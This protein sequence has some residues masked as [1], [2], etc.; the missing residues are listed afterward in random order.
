MTLLFEDGLTATEVLA[1]WTEAEPAASALKLI[2]ATNW[3]PLTVLMLPR[4]I[5]IVP[6]LAALVASILKALLEPS[7]DENCNK[8][9]GKVMSA[10]TA[11]TSV[12]TLMR[13]AI[14]TVE[15]TV[16]LPDA[17]LRY[18]ELVPWALIKA[19]L[20][21][22]PTKAAVVTRAPRA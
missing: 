4:E 8:L 3:S 5:L 14:L 18:I 7:I 19:L 20:A 1:N 13:T 11:L 21:P 9:V 22:L 17:G 12:E 15:P 10:W 6:P 2:L 16:K